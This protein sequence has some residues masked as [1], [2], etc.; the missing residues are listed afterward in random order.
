[1]VLLYKKCGAHWQE[2]LGEVQVRYKKRDRP[3]T[4][5]ELWNARQHTKPPSLA[6]NTRYE[7]GLLVFSM[8][9]AA[10]TGMQLLLELHC[11]VQKVVV[12]VS[13]S[14]RVCCQ[15]PVYPFESVPVF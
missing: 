13:N 14:R 2:R 5:V 10:S 15:R 4:V 1:M 12:V 7:P 9:A 3:D 6:T 8:C 11:T